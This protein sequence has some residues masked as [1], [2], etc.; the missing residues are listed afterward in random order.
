M[1]GA[2]LRSPVAQAS[3]A[4]GARPAW[5]GFATG[6]GKRVAVVLA[7]CGVYDGAE[8]TEATA[9][10]VHLS[11]ARAEV[12]CFAPDKPQM[13]AVDH[14]M[15]TEHTETRNVLKE[16][17]RIARGAVVPLAD[18]KAADFDAVV[19]PGGFG[20]AKNLSSWAVD[21]TRC[22][23]DAD[24]VR[25]IKDFH[26]SSKVLGMC[27]IA[28]TLAAKVLGKVTV[29]VGQEEGDAWPYAGTAGQISSL[30]ATHVKTTISEICVDK[31][32]KLVTS[33]AYMYD[34]RPHEIFDNVGQ[35]IGGVLELA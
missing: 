14:T 5:R 25:V 21:G 22:S 31:E 15:G 4:L 35:M 32:N 18:L 26:S 8:I 23:V 29:T 3:L 12:R 13:H 17:A 7:G 24:V 11:R 10:L 34:G 2:L 1:F 20:A 30:G 9:C 19:F 16:S 6:A 28:P 27:C 33:P